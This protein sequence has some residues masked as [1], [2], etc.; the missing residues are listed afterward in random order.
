MAIRNAMFKYVIHKCY[1]LHDTLM[2][3]FNGYNCTAKENIIGAG[4]VDE[5]PITRHNN[6]A[7]LIILIFLKLCVRI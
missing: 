7:I 5:Y 1:K 3:I 4:Y 6:C 2:I